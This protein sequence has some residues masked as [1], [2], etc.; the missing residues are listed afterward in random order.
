MSELPKGWVVAQIG[1]LLQGITAGKNLKCEERPPLPHEQGV[2]KV[3]AVTWG[4]FDPSESKTLP[5]NFSPALDTRIKAGDFLFSRANTVELVGAVVLVK[6]DHP[7]L[8][9]SDKILR[10]DFPS[11]LKPWLRLYLGGAEGRRKLSEVSSGNQMS[12][13]NIGQEALR[14]VAVPIA[15]QPE[16]HRIVAKIEELFSELDASEESLTR[17]RAQLGLYRQSLLKAAFQGKLTADWRAANPDKLESPEA[18]LSRIRKEREDRYRQALEDWQTALSEWRAKGEVGRK[19]AKPGRP[20]AIDIHPNILELPS[21]PSG[22]TWV[23][24]SSVGDVET[25][26]TPPTKNPEYFGGSVPFFKPTDL[27]AGIHTTVARDHLTDEGLE[28]SRSFPAGSVLV[29]CIGATIGKTGLVSVGGA[30]NQQI[31]FIVPDGLATSKFTFFQITGPAFQEEIMQNANSTTLPILNKS[32]FS[33]LP[34][35][36]CSLDE[37]RE[38]EDILDTQLSVIDATETEI[39]TALTK[40]TALRQS[41]LKKAFAGELVPQDP[42]DEP[43][44]ALLARIRAEVPV[45]SSRRKKTA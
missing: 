18:L 8:Y 25:G 15:P 21:V 4:T 16:Q 40:I 7:N 37:Q 14:S 11:E 35:A 6:E 5:P 13:R 27:D 30:C 31:N 29:T 41:I 26:N 44:S 33:S 1:E 43:A 22:W 2:I 20:S 39:T 28:V 42:A 19:P 12:M 45:Q 9:L 38:I 17:A 32:K 23:T 36:V 24:T 3:S 10:L 34:F